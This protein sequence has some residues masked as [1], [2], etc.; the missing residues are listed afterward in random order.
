MGMMLAF[1]LTAVAQE[2]ALAE[3]EVARGEKPRATCAFAR[4]EESGAYELLATWGRGKAPTLARPPKAFG[5]M[6]QDQVRAWALE[7]VQASFEG[8]WSDLTDPE[9]GPDTVDRGDGKKIPVG[10]R[11]ILL[12]AYKGV[13][14]SDPD[15]YSDRAGVSAFVSDDLTGETEGP[16]RARFSVRR[17]RV[18]KEHGPAKKVVAEKEVAAAL[19][20]DF[21]RRHPELKGEEVEADVVLCWAVKPGEADR[22]VPLW[23]VELEG[24]APGRLKPE[25]H[26]YR[27]DA[28]TGAILSSTPV[29][30]PGIAPPPPPPK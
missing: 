15:A 13:V 20:K 18:V 8:D 10:W 14:F 9:T 28:W 29:A 24:R 17:W 27:V 19:R 30:V 12:Q 6:T 7:V 16:S 4:D 26:V 22:R 1:V 11:L 25:L 23:R 5:A 21:V 2:T 3:I